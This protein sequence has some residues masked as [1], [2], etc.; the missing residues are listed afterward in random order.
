MHGCVGLTTEECYICP[1]GT[2]TPPDMTPRDRCLPCPEGTYGYTGVVGG[3]ALPWTGLRLGVKCGDFADCCVA[4]LSV[5]LCVSLCVCAE[6]AYFCKLCP[7]GSYNNLTGQSGCPLCPTG[8]TNV[9]K[10]SVICVEIV[11]MLWWWWWCDGVAA[12]ATSVVSL[13]AVIVVHSVGRWWR[14]NGPVDSVGVCDFGCH[15]CHHHHHL[16]RQVGLGGRCGGW[17]L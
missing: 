16:R 13:I 14:S 3:T 8:Y 17:W 6:G 1:L 11:S 5:T 7:V 4:W 2:Y 15:P 9:N 12:V 10:G